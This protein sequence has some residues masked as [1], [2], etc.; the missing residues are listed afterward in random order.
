[1]KS[2]GFILQ[3]ACMVVICSTEVSAQQTSRPDTNASSEEKH[4]VAVEELPGAIKDNLDKDAFMGW[5]AEAAY[6]NKTK[7]WYE[8]ELR[9]ATEVKTVKFTKDGII[10]E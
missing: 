3:M 2:I 5:K 7:D 8:V 10:V 9:N 1:M 6:Y 4:K